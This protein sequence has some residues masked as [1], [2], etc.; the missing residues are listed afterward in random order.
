MVTY[1]PVPE[2]QREEFYRMIDYAFSPHEEEKNYEDE[3]DFWPGVGDRRGIY[4]DEELRA[5]ASI[6]HFESY[7]RDDWLPMGGVSTVATPPEY[8]HRGY[9]R[10]MMAELLRELRG[11]EIILSS[12]WPFSYPFYNKLGWK[13]SARSISYSFEPEALEFSQQ[14]KRGSFRSISVEE[15]Q[16]IEP[17]YHDFLKQFNLGLRR[18]S[19]WWDHHKLNPW[20]K[21]TYCYAWELNGEDRGYVIYTVN[22]GEESSWKKEMEVREFVYQDM[23]ACYHLLRFLYN[24]GS[25]M[26]QISLS[27]PFPKDTT[28]LDFVEDPRD[29][30]AELKPGVMVRCVDVKQALETLTYPPELNGKTLLA[31]TDPLLDKNDGIYSL[32]FSSEETGCQVYRET[33][34]L[35]DPDCTVDIGTLSQIFTGYLTPKE[36][37]LTDDLTVESEEKL[38]LLDRAFPSTKI[39][40][41]D[42]F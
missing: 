3:E 39:F 38:S 19:E 25:Q 32:N 29:V 26:E 14:E 33:S 11:K 6:H 8:R 20:Q 28:L 17:V 34:D 35:Q 36:A 10:T 21:P 37:V 15:Y 12:L 18:S 41:N 40:F 23:E 22:E 31:V 1:R 27:T 30:E 9:V 7:L 13:A 42:G 4:E 16:D 2:E 5:I 24:H